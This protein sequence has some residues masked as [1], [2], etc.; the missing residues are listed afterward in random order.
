MG[1]GSRRPRASPASPPAKKAATKA[2]NAVK[3]VT[4]ESCRVAK[5]AGKRLSNSFVAGTQVLMADGTMSQL[6]N[7]AVA[8][9]TARSREL[10]K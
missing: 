8:A 5:G 9:A 1:P 4:Q 3:S 6:V 7:R 10:A 2:R